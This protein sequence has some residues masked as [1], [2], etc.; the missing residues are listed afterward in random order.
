MNKKKYFLNI[1]LL[2]K[3]KIKKKWEKKYQ[4]NEY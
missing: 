3:Q 1:F 4:L 2:H